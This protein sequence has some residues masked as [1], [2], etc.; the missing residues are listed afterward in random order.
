MAYRGGRNGLVRPRPSYLSGGGL[1]LD[2]GSLYI[3]TEET[4]L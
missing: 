1:F 3:I 4:C 2:E